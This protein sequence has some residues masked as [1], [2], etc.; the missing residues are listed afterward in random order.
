[1]I[2]HETVE[3]LFVQRR[4]EIYVYLVSLGVRPEEAQ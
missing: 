2:L 4:E 3:R 1:M